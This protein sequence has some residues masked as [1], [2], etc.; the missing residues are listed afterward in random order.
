M[1]VLDSSEV[2]DFTLETNATHRLLMQ[3]FWPGPLTL[4]FEKNSRVSDLCTAGSKFVAIRSPKNILFRDMLKRVGE[5]LSAPSANLFGQISP[6]T[7]EHVVEELGARG[8]EAVVDGGPCEAGLESTIVKVSNKGSVEILR[9]GAVSAEKLREALG[10]E[11]PVLVSSSTGPVEV[12]GQ[13]ESHYAPRA[14]VKIVVAD[15]E[16]MTELDSNMDLQKHSLLSV[17]PP[18]ESWTKGKLWR[19]VRILSN[20]FSDVEAASK[21]FLYLRELDSESPQQ[22]WALVPKADVGLVAA[23]KDRLSRAAAKRR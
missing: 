5:P 15:Q 3:L 7:A 23:I 22:I 8:L 16:A 21:L 1:H 2:K 4:L 11:R 17:Y 19:S 12:P 18:H 10:P 20:N 9:L 6:T 13:L 14:L